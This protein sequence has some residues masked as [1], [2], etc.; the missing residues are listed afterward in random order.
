MGVAVIAG[1][2]LRFVGGR[3]VVEQGSQPYHDDIRPFGSSDPFGKAGD[4]QHMV[5]VMGSVASLIEQT[6]LFNGEQGF[7]HRVDLYRFPV[8]R[9]VLEKTSSDA[10]APSAKKARI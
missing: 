5:K 9:S 4:A 7:C 10:N 6:D 8:E 1:Q 3:K 2:R